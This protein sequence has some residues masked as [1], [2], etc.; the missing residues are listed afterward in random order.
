M[1]IALTTDVTTI[2]ASDTKS[3]K[4]IIHRNKDDGFLFKYFSKFGYNCK[5][6]SRLSHHIDEFCKI[7]VMKLKD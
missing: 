5:G 2:C 4:K 1:A 3:H 6:T 7:L